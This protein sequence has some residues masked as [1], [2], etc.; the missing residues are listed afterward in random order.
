MTL[1]KTKVFTIRLA[2]P[3]RFH[4]KERKAPDG[5]FSTGLK[6]SA[7]GP[8]PLEHILDVMAGLQKAAGTAARPRTQPWT[9][10]TRLASTHI[11]SPKTVAMAWWGK[12]ARVTAKVTAAWHVGRHLEVFLAGAIVAWHHR[13]A[14]VTA[15][16]L[17]NKL[18][19]ATILTDIKTRGVEILL[20]NRYKFLS[21]PAV[22]GLKLNGSETA[23]TLLSARHRVSCN[24]RERDDDDEW[25][26]EATRVLFTWTFKTALTYYFLFCT[27]F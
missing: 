19:S 24:K 11:T 2:G 9:I 7:V 14:R 21:L 18:F 4:F 17:G 13:A 12:H 8:N 6:A 1:V 5:L 26:V 25:S 20:P 22:V 16:L 10:A 23:I 3:L 27:V 15:R